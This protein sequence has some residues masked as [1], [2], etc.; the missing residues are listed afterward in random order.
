MSFGEGI[1][2]IRHSFLPKRV[3]TSLTITVRFVKSSKGIK[4]MI[5]LKMRRG[6]YSSGVTKFMYLDGLRGN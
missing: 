4:T 6:S 1:E 3:S 2:F 5:I